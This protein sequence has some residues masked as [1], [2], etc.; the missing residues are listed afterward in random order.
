MLCECLGKV[1]V[2]SLSCAYMCMFNG[3]IVLW[4][5]LKYFEWVQNILLKGIDILNRLGVK[6][7]IHQGIVSIKGAG[8]I[9]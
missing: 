7:N 9:K 1:C 6:F 4:W 2:L 3:C 8:N 5:F